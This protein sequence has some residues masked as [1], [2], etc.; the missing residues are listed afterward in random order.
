MPRPSTEIETARVA[1]VHAPR[2]LVAFY[3][4]DGEFPTGDHDLGSKQRIAERLADLLGLEF[5]G[6]FDPARGN[7]GTVYFVPSHTLCDPRQARRL[8]IRCAD[9]LFGGVVPHPFVATKVISHPL[10]EASCHA[11]AG[12]SSTFGERVRGA[13]LPGYS[14]FSAVD[15]LRAGA[16]LLESGAVRIKD[17]AGVGG[18]GQW[19]VS[20]G[21]ELGA[22]L[23]AWDASALP[24]KGLVLERNLSHVV[25][26]S[27]GQVQVGDSVTTYCG[28]QTST[29]NHRGEDVYGGSD[30]LLARGGFQQLLDLDLSG[31]VRTAVEQALAYHRAALATFGGMFASR[32]NYDVAQGVDDDGRPCSG[33]LE[34]SWRVGGASGAEVA[35]LHAFAADPGL[36]VVRACTRERYG[37]AAPVPAG[38]WVLFDGVDPRVGRITKIAWVAPDGHD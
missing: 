16:R 5:A 15:A 32:C 28:V 30:L 7:A 17:P 21:A 27:V 29:P 26:H 37:E 13:V 6:L 4:C 12:W 25:T 1:T 8:G 33:V 23:C 34:Q 20:S 24:H 2:R 22:R 18:A 31:P 36:R 10:L 9:D 35:A 11:P 38:A 3:P 19:V 14:V